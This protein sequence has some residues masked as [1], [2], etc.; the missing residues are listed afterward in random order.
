[1]QC[2]HAATILSAT[3]KS[4]GGTLPTNVSKLDVHNRYWKLPMGSSPSPAYHLAAM[5]AFQRKADIGTQPYTEATG[6]IT[7]VGDED[8]KVCSGDTSGAAHADMGPDMG[9]G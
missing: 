3:P 8:W 1:M 6:L 4:D 5:A 7:A 9:Q 2:V